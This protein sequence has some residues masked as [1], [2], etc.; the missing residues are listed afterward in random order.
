[1]RAAVNSQISGLA[2]FRIGNRGRREIPALNL[3]VPS[4]LDTVTDLM[5]RQ[6]GRRW[7]KQVA[8]EVG[9]SGASHRRSRHWEV[10][11]ALG[12]PAVLGTRFRHRQR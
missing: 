1:M 9:Q 3:S 6:P 11:G 7:I 8:V 12:A 5:K 4:T 2:L 10:G